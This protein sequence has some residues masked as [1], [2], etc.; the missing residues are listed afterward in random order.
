[1]ANFFIS[2]EPVT[3]SGNISAFETAISSMGQALTV[4]DSLVLLNTKFDGTEVFN[5]LMIEAGESVRFV[6]VPASTSA[7]LMNVRP[8][9]L[10]TFHEFMD[11]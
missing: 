10:E 5:R 1:M 2:Y 9:I 3:G 8:G 11:R 4:H 7:S 6:S